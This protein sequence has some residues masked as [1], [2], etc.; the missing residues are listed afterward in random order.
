MYDRAAIDRFGV[1]AQPN[2]PEDWP[3]ERR[4]RVHA[5][6]LKA[7]GQ[8]KGARPK[9]KCAGRP[10]GK[11]HRATGVRATRRRA[12]AASSEAPTRRGRG[13]ATVAGSRAKRR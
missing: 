12:R 4:K 5:Q 9:A 10:G 3:L 1:F 2:F 13:R 7:N 6:W 11:G 8:R